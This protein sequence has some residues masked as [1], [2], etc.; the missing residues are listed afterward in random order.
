[1][2]SLTTP[3]RTS[4][5]AGLGIMRNADRS[6]VYSVLHTD[7]DVAGLSPGDGDIELNDMSASDNKWQIQMNDEVANTTDIM[8][9]P[10][11]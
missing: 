10:G 1:M 6:P 11:E 3:A 9:N 7:G 4:K 2:P 8:A 5:N